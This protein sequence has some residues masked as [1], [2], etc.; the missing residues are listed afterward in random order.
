MASQPSQFA[1]KPVPPLHHRLFYATTISSIQ[2]SQNITAW[3]RGW[4]EYFKPIPNAADVVKTYD[5]R[6][7]LPIR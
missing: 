5:A 6:P 7:K 4:Q 3:F 1:T 2:T